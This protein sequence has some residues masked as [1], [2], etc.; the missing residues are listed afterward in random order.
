MWALWR[1]E[2]NWRPTSLYIY[3]DRVRQRGEL[4]PILAVPV[5][6]W[7]FSKLNS[8]LGRPNRA[9]I[10]ASPKMA[11]DPQLRQLKFSASNIVIVVCQQNFNFSF[12]FKPHFVAG[13]FS[14]ACQS[15]YAEITRQVVHIESGVPYHH[16]ARSLG[17]ESL[18]SVSPAHPK[19]TN[20]LADKM[21]RAN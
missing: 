17:W 11:R 12:N 2:S 16:H 14:T 15:R 7:A 5:W 1:E 3:G 4:V 19:D 20:T 8:R 10:H 21:N 13:T 9:R 6:R 18:S